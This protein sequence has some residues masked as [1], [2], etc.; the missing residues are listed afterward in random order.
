L[1]L[2]SPWYL[3][4]GMG[5]H[6]STYLNDHF[7]GSTVGLE[8]ARRIHGENKDNAFGRR[9]EP[10]VE[11]IDADR[12]QLQQLMDALEVKR[13]PLK[14]VAGFFGEKLGR[15]KL[16]GSILS[17]SPLS[18]LVELEM[19]TL[20]VQGKLAL[21]KTLRTTGAADAAIGPFELDRLISRAEEQA[22]T[23]E[24]LRLAAAREA[25]GAADDSDSIGRPTPTARAAV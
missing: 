7:A 22:A 20:G 14:T 10:L 24:E 19:L 1:T 9:I 6:L 13:D 25:L 5:S 2:A 17:Y 12:K 4:L 15:L 21:W 18:R 8:L 11:E 16:N 3:N 23:L